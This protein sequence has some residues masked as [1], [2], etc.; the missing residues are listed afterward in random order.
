MV[1]TIGLAVPAAAGV[2]I[3]IG[4]NSTWKVTSTATTSH[5]TRAIGQTLTGTAKVA[6][7]AKIL[8]IPLPVTGHYA[9]SFPT[10]FSRPSLKSYTNA[11][12]TSTSYSQLY[13]AHLGRTQW[14]VRGKSSFWGSKT[15]TVVGDAKAATKATRF[16]YSGTQSCGSGCT[17]AHAAVRIITN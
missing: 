1:A 12:L 14:E 3:G 4:G 9:N 10:T 6:F 17:N 16:F 7:S 5:D 13:N 15:V 2:S 11:D 8:G